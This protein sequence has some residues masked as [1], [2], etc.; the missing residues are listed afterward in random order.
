MTA[1]LLE[2]LDHHSVK[3]LLGDSAEIFSP[4]QGGR[5][6]VALKSGRALGADLV[7]LGV[8]V[9]PESKLAADAGLEIGARGGIRVDE[10]LR[11]S[12]PNIYAIGDVIEVT[13]FVLQEPTQIPLAGPANRQGR[14]A[15][16][17]IFGRAQRYR[18]TQGTAIVRHFDCVAAMTGASEKLLRQ[19]NRAHRAVYVH[20]GNHAGYYQPAARF[21]ERRLSA[22][23]P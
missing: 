20:P 6:S 3:L 8:G 10:H 16:D 12:D 1:P 11:T 22:A 15:A 4:I 23:P 5:T 7:V 9:R 17:N 2:T 13:D 21:S 19:K 14:I 18:G